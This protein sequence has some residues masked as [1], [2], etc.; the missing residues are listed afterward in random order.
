MSLYVVSLQVHPLPA[1]GSTAAEESKVETGA[2]S[3]PKV[4]AP[5]PPSTS[6]GALLNA[7][8]MP[9][10]HIVCLKYVL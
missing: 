4:T 6:F 5:P 2:A 8:G 10:V 3:K 9:Y 1:S 7:A